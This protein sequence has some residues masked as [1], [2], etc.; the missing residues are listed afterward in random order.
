MS[1]TASAM[2]MA[3]A[4]ALVASVKDSVLDWDR[5][6][7][8]ALARLPSASGSGSVWVPPA[9]SMNCTTPSIRRVR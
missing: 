5:Q 2:A 7:V 4:L 6:A 8:L 3:L 9:L 1:V